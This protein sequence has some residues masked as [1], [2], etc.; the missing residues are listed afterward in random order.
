MNTQEITVLHSD[1]LDVCGRTVTVS[2][3]W[4]ANPLWRHETTVS[5]DD[6]SHVVAIHAGS[7][8]AI[9]SH[10]HFTCWP[11]LALFVLE[12]EAAK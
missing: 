12:A 4:L 8:H 9:Q 7:L 2:T 11:V 3:V 6:H 5:W 1:V 10:I